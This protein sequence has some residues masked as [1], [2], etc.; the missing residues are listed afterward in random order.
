MVAKGAVTE[1]VMPEEGEVAGPLPRHTEQRLAFSN[2]AADA[3]SEYIPT[4]P[5]PN[6]FWIY[7]GV[8]LIF[9]SFSAFC[10]LR[11]KSTP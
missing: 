4:A 9:C 5:T 3:I 2:E 1:E 6:R 10:L 7:V 11:N 8:A